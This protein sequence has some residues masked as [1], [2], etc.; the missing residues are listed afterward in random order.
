ML[1]DQESQAIDSATELVSQG[2]L[3]VAESV[4]FT[5]LSRAELYVRMSRG[6]VK[7]CK[8]GKRRLIPKLALIKMMAASVVASEHV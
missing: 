4:K 8:E 6:E 5:G 7:Y 2:R 3:S 1:N